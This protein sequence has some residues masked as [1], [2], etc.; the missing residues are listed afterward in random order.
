MKA[1]CIAS[2]S[3][4]PRTLEASA[5]RVQPGTYDYV[6]I[7]PLNRTTFEPR[8]IAVYANSAQVLRLVHAALYSRGGRVV[9]TSGGRLGCAEI[10]IQT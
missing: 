7:A 4:Q 10:V 6:C 2:T 1:G 9:S 5:W 3:R 8:V